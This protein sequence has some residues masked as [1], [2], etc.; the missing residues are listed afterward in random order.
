MEPGNQDKTL[1]QRDDVAG[2][3]GMRNE[4]IPADQRKDGTDQ[5][6]PCESVS[7]LDLSFERFITHG[8]LR[9]AERELLGE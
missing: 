7:P 2:E 6:H 4:G 1:G 8:P 9:P 3:V 5:E